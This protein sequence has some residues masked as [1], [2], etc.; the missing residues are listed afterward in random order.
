M[1]LLLFLLSVPII[2]FFLSTLTPSDVSSVIFLVPSGLTIVVFLIVFCTPFLKSQNEIFFE[3]RFQIKGNSVL[4]FFF[5]SFHVITLLLSFEIQIC[6]YRF[7]LPLNYY[8]RRTFTACLLRF[9]S[10][11]IHRPLSY[12]SRMTSTI[13]QFHLRS[14]LY[15]RRNCCLL[16][17]TRQTCRWYC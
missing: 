15:Y 8:S 9:R 11:L 4:V 13:S 6:W 17:Q 5:K 7:H 2:Y 1:L 12:H 3:N 16:L 14:L 10:L